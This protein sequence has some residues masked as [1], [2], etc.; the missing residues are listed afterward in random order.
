MYHSNGV[1][2]KWGTLEEKSLDLFAEFVSYQTEWQA[3]K[4]LP[5]NLDI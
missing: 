2:R 3:V 1:W 5:Y 4:Y